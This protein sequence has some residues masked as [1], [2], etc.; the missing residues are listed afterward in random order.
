VQ[1]K[2]PI[3]ITIKESEK[4]ELAGLEEVLIGAFGITGLLLLGAL[5]LGA[6]LA[7]VMFWI[8]S[9]SA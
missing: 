9:R 2:D 6:V 5:L 7:G 1:K 3:L 4:S 8:R